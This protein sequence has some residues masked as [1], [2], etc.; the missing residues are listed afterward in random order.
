MDPND[1]M[2]RPG[3][4]LTRSDVARRLGVTTTTV[5]R[6][7]G[8]TLHPEIGDDGV[9]L[10]TRDEVERLAHARAAKPAPE[11]TGEVA[12]E[13][14]RLFR[15]GYDLAEIVMRLKQPPAAIRRLFDEWCL[16]L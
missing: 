12:A 14:F 9:R 11:A 1:Q 16:D 3:R 6:L 8:T 10:F 5:R 2:A 15:Q 13:A 7:E 4:R